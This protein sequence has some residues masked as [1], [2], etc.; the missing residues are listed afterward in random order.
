MRRHFKQPSFAIW[1]SL[2]LLLLATTA[3]VP[4][5][6]QSGANTGLAGRVVDESDAVLPGV[7]ITITRV[8]T[9]EESAV[10]SDE[11]GDWEARFLSPGSYRLVFSL[12]GFKTMNR[13]GVLG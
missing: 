6:A 4:V 5:L 12:P 11:L 10:V 1:G 13:E 2:C 7:D 9:G 3:V 8:E